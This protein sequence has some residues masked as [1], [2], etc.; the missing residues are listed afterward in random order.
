M[1][2][3]G[4]VVKAPASLRHERDAQ[5]GA[6][7]G[8]QYAESVAVKSHL[9]RG[10]RQKTHHALEERRLAHA[11]AAHETRPRSGRHLEIDVP[12]G[13]TAAVKLIQAG[14]R[15]HAHSPRYTS[16]TRGSACT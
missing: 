13:V 16:T 1:C 15:E 8:L 5:Q 9:T 14:N 12:E 3:K 4:R 6:L 7:I 2:V 10:S 11:V